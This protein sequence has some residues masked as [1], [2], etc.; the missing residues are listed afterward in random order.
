MRG[1]RENG[2]EL[3]SQLRSA[4]SSG[5]AR[6]TS[7]SPAPTVGKSRPRAPGPRRRPQPPPRPGHYAASAAPARPGSMASNAGRASK[8]GMIFAETRRLRMPYVPPGKTSSS[9]AD[10]EPFPQSANTPRRGISLGMKIARRPARNRTIPVLSS[11]RT[12]LTH[13]AAI[14][15]PYHAPG[16]S[17]PA[18]S[19]GPFTPTSPFPN[20]HR[21]PQP[22]IRPSWPN[23]A[24]SSPRSCSG[25]KSW[26][27]CR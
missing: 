24:G 6:Q 15:H 1:R 2:S 5:P 11:G 18:A 8:S 20:R 9:L 19:R 25:E 14:D 16:A 12:E 7:M 22:T 4:G 27:H 17:R 10:P 26:K 21:L 23:P 13:C 3:C